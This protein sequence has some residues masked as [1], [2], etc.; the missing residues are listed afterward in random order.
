MD[1]V[2]EIQP[3]LEGIAQ[4]PPPAKHGVFQTLMVM[5]D[6]RGAPLALVRVQA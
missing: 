1:V 3:E 5:G 4:A 2:S 6:A